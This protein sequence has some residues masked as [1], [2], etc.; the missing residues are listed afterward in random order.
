[1]KKKNNSGWIKKEAVYTYMRETSSG[2]FKGDKSR[3]RKEEQKGLLSGY[4]F[5]IFS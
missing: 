3:E 2:V 5:S 1:M 4:L